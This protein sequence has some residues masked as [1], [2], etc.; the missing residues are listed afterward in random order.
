[1]KNKHLL[2]L[3]SIVSVVTVVPAQIKVSCIGNSITQGT[4]SDAVYPAILQTLLTNKYLVENDGVSGTT[5]LKA[6][7]HPYWTQGR[8]SNVFAFKPNIVTIKLGTN[9]TKP[10]NWDAHYNVFKTDYLAMIDTLNTLSTKPRIFLVLPVPIWTNS[11]SIRDSALQ[12]ILVI[13][14]QIAMERG[15][16]VIDANTPLLGFQS[17]FPDGVHPNAAGADSIA[18]IFSRSI[19]GS[20]Q[21]RFLYCS[22][23]TNI[24]TLPYRMFIPE[25]YSRQTKYPMVLTLHG[26]GERGSDNVLQVSRYRIAEIW[27]EDS[28]QQAHKCFVVSPQCPVK[29][30]WVDVD[31]TNQ[32]LYKTDAVAEDTA[33]KIAVKLVDSLVKIFPIDTNR[34]YV[35]GLSMGGFATWDIISRHPGKFAAAVPLAGGDDTSKASLIK[36]TPLW[37]FQGAVDPTVPPQGTRAMVAKLKS[38]GVPFVTYDT[39]YGTSSGNYF[40]SSTMTR[41]AINAAIDAGA[42]DLYCEYYDGIHDI[43][44]K[45]YNEP[46]LIKW[47]FDQQKPVASEAL[48]TA[49]AI[50]RRAGSASVAAIFPGANV[51]DIVKPFMHSG[52]CELRVFN[53]GGDLVGR[54]IVNGSSFTPADVN[55]ILTTVR[56][57]CWVSVKELK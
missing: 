28:V 18:A 4:S 44:V 47:M 12:K 22:D 21:Y 15:L 32:V 23:S 2:F 57:L 35:T 37:T 13:V 25:N 41:A 51:F 33:I 10:Q 43:W 20:P 36:N 38:L 1:M 49:P 7:D 16:P 54:R 46:M 45:T 24:G 52:R 53:A 19:A 40:D 3:L 29:W 30:R 17:Y 27:A 34:I 50:V 9:D 31:Y 42:K 26:M 14:K 56:G 8:L 5:M 6:G 11:Y 39:K 55:G 48:V